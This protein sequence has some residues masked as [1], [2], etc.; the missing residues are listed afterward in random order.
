MTTEPNSSSEQKFNELI[1]ASNSTNK[2]NVHCTRCSSL[3]LRKNQGQF[4]C[5]TF[6]IPLPAQSKAE[7]QKSNIQSEPLSHY[8]VVNDIYTF[9]NIGFTNATNQ[10]KYLICADCEIGPLGFMN[11][12]NQK[13]I[14]LAIER[15]KHE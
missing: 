7:L 3:I 14:F 15:V 10:K 13:E 4:C 12:D 11:V 9:E 6:D 5:Q 8:W 1:D 2:Q